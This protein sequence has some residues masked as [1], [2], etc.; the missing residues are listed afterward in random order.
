MERFERVVRLHRILSAA[1]RPVSR[2]RLMEELE[3]SR[4][5]L[6]RVVAF[7]RDHL[8]APLESDEAQGFYYDRRLA[9]VYELPGLWLDARELVALLTAWQVISSDGDG[10]LDEAMR[11]LRQ[12]IEQLLEAVHPGHGS[13]LQKITVLR[14]AS[15]PVDQRVFG[16]LAQALME[17]RRLDM[18]Y[19]GRIRAEDSR[20]QVS[21]LRLVWYRHNWYLMAWCHRRDALR[22]FAVERIAQPRLLEEAAREVDQQALVQQME[23]GY[24]LFTGEQVQWAEIRFS[25]R[26]ARWVAEESWHPNQQ[27]TWQGDGSYLL[28]LPY[29]Q[30][31]ELIMDVARHGPDAEIL[32]PDGL[33]QQMRDFLRRS[34]E[35]Y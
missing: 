27:G 21:P 14:Q 26:A 32:A 7:L 22:S 9:G 18:D 8:G 16:L 30:P 17:G 28:R 4:A 13:L 25:P 34:L 1:R 24:G 20:R 35:R 23:A 3:C 2:Q 6:Y 31:V 19:Q 10:L 15:R 12:K 5:T 33:R 29:V 11:P